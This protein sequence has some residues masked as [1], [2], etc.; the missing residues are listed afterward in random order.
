[1]SS[2]RQSI[3]RMGGFLGGI[4]GWAIGFLNGAVVL[5]TAGAHPYIA[6]WTTWACIFG[7]PLAATCPAKFFTRTAKKRRDAANESTAKT[8]SSSNGMELHWRDLAP[9]VLTVA[10]VEG[11]WWHAYIDAVPGKDGAREASEVVRV[12]AR[13]P[14]EIAGGIW[15]HLALLYEYRG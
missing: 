3:G 6:L 15:P 2:Q 10:V 9:Q 8:R 12:G 4:V 14:E 11:T 13:L 7:A 1:M 5:S